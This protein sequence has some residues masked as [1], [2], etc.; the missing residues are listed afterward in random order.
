MLRVAC[1]LLL[2]ARA[3]AAPAPPATSTPPRRADT[4][5]LQQ[6]NPV[7]IDYE[8][9]P[10]DELISPHQ[11]NHGLIMKIK[12]STPP[13]NNRKLIVKKVPCRKSD[14]KCAHTQ[15][16]EF[17]LFRVEPSENRTGVYY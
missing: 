4:V 8:G 13:V 2:T 7:V 17:N 12:R 9:R 16:Y 14:D 15:L 5:Q 10:E 1:L 3:L 6:T 11:Q